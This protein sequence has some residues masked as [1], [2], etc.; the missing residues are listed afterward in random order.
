V[1]LVGGQG[2]LRRFQD[3]AAVELALQLMTS[4]MRQA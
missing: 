2:N 1:I 3:I 4:P